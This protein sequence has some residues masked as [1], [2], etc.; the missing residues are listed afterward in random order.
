M[1][2]VPYSGKPPSPCTAHVTYT[3]T[4]HVPDPADPYQTARVSFEPDRSNTLPGAITFYLRFRIR[5]TRHF[6]KITCD[7]TA[8]VI[9]PDFIRKF[10]LP[11]RTASRISTFRHGLTTSRKLVK[12]ESLH[13]GRLYFRKTCE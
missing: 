6:L 8:L 12:L 7:R 4:N 10:S 2:H 3:P 11:F 5:I 1:F 13:I 9:A